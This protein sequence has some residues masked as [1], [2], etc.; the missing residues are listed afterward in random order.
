LLD[1]LVNNLLLLS[2]KL[3]LVLRHCL[4]PLLIVD[5]LRQFTVQSV[6]RIQG[7][8]QRDINI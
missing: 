2:F 1:S 4:L 7:F 3:L 8:S 6:F 5:L